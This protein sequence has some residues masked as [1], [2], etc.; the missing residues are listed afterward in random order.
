MTEKEKITKANKF[1]LEL[2]ALIEKHEVHE[3]EPCESDS[4]FDKKIGVVF[5]Y[6][7]PCPEDKKNTY[8]P[9]R[10]WVFSTHREWDSK[11]LDDPKGDDVCADTES[12]PPIEYNRSKK[13]KM[14][15]Q[16]VV[17]DSLSH[18]MSEKK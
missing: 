13:H 14:T 1:F 16:R 2:K 6:D 5:N 8:Y 15:V 11:G 10:S 12:Q 9:G 3:F 17:K 18:L 7:G 4:E